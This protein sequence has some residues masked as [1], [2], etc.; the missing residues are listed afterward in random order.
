M[1][2]NH[3]CSVLFCKKY[4]KIDYDKVYF[5]KIHNPSR[6]FKENPKEERVTYDLKNGKRIMIV[7]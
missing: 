3:R 1:K 2:L 7:K 4:G 5:C 6:Y